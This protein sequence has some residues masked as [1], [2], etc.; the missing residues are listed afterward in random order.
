M[1]IL[2][3]IDGTPCPPGEAFIPV[4]DRGFLFGDSV[5]ET[6]RVYR[7]VPFMREEHLGRLVRSAAGLGFDLRS[8]CEPLRSSIET[9]LET[10]RCR[11]GLLRVVVTRGSSGLTLSLRGLPEVPRTILFYTALPEDHDARLAAGFTLHV[12]KIERTSREALDPAIKSGNKL[13]NILALAEAER[14]GYDDCLMLNGQGALAE[15]SSSNL[16]VVRAGE[17]LTPSLESGIL[18]GITR[19]VLL[20][21]CSHHGLPARACTLG[22]N[23]LFQA[24]EA[25]LSSTSREV[26]AVKR[27]DNLVLPEAPGPLTR[28]LH[29]LF[30]LFIEDYCERA[31]STDHCA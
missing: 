18:D 11:N 8:R 26:V 10:A 9:L 22:L 29:E 28:R 20:D 6:L 2:V 31:T 13:N 21:L 1:E 4:F 12:P 25:F 30:K 23:D 16:F 17:V 7:G 15:L 14:L 24:E 19:G 3:S 5:Y 27:I